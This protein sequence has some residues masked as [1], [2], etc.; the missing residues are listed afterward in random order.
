MHS[1]YLN[2]ISIFLNL[3]DLSIHKEKYSDWIYIGK[4][5]EGFDDIPHGVGIRVWNNGVT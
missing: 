3:F 2:S 1:E 4:V 5:K